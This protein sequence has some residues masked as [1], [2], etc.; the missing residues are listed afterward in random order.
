MG[1]W[2]SWGGGGGGGGM[3]SGNEARVGS[4]F[5]LLPFIIYDCKGLRFFLKHLG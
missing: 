3:E 2:L 4:R 5:Y 1:G